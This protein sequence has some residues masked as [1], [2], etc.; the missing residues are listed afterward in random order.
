MGGEESLEQAVKRIGKK[1]TAR[2]DLDRRVS[3]RV[4]STKIRNGWDYIV[5]FLKNL[6]LSWF[7]WR[8]G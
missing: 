4:P 6:D 1:R 7:F 2:S 8:K 5:M 3:T